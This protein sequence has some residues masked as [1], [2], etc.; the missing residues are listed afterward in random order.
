MAKVKIPSVLRPLS[1]GAPFLE[2]SADTLSALRTDL[3]ARFPVLAARVYGPDGALQ[4]YVSLFV[5]GDDA[6]DLP[7]DAPLRENS[8]VL[9]LPAVSGG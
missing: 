4:E 1:G 3:A 8:E 9:L 5:D 2:S 7:P 6:R